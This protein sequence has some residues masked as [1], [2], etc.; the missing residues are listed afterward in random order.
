MIA[1]LSPKLPTSAFTESQARYMLGMR[2]RLD[3]MVGLSD[4][5][6]K[7]P[8]DRAASCPVNYRTPCNAA[9]SQLPNRPNPHILIGALVS[10]LHCVRVP[11]HA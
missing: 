11:N 1:H 7:Q 3:F 8:A 10:S 9:T 5:S 4:K 2:F 6:P